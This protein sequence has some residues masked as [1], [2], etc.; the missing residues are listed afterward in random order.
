MTTIAP[1]QQLPSRKDSEGQRVQ[2]KKPQKLKGKQK[3][4]AKQAAALLAREYHKDQMQ[5]KGKIKTFFKE[6]V[7]PIAL[8]VRQHRI[9]MAMKKNRV[10][11][12]S[13]E[14][15]KFAAKTTALE[16]RFG[17]FR[18]N[19]H[20]GD[21]LEALKVSQEISEAHKTLSE[22]AKGQ[23]HAERIK[24]I[25]SIDGAGF[26]GDVKKTIGE[27]LSDGNMTEE[28]R[29]AKITKLLD[30]ASKDQRFQDND[31]VKG[32]VGTQ[33]QRAQTTDAIKAMV[34]ALRPLVGKHDVGL[35]A[36]DSL[37]LE[38]SGKNLYRMQRTEALWKGSGYV[39]TA[40]LIAIGFATGGVGGAVAKTLES[41]VLGSIIGYP[42]NLHRIRYE[43]FAHSLDLA[44]GANPN[45]IKTES[46]GFISGVAGLVGMSKYIPKVG[47][48]MEPVVRAAQVVRKVD[49]VRLGRD[50]DPKIRLMALQRAITNSA[51]GLAF[52]Y[53]LRW[54]EGTAPGQ[55]VSEKMGD[56]A[57]FA[58]STAPGK[59]V[60][61]GVTTAQRDVQQLWNSVFGEKP[62]NGCFVAGT[63][64]LMADRSSKPIEQVVVGEM[65]FSYDETLKQIVTKKVLA[66]ISP[67]SQVM[68]TITFA[69]GIKTTNTTNHRYLV[70]DKG[71]SSFDPLAT[72]EIDRVAVAKFVVGDK[73]HVY[74]SEGLQELE[75]TNL[76][77]FEKQTQTYNLA[78]IE[79]THTFFANN[80]LVHNKFKVQTGGLKPKQADVFYV[81]RTSDGGPVPV[82]FADGHDVTINIPKGTSIL[83]STDRSTIY[84]V[85]NSTGT[86]VASGHIVGTNLELD[87]LNGDKATDSIPLP[88]ETSGG[89]ATLDAAQYLAQH[90][91]VPVEY[92]GDPKYWQDMHS[93]VQ[94]GPGGNNELILKYTGPGNYISLV[95]PNNHPPTAL[96]FSNSETPQ[97][98]VLD[99][100]Q[101]DVMHA[102]IGAD[103]KPTG[104]SMST[105]QILDLLIDQKQKG[106]TAQ[107]QIDVLGAAESYAKG[108][109]SGTQ[110][111]QDLIYRM[112]QVLGVKQFNN[113]QS[114][115]TVRVG[116]GDLQNGVMKVGAA[117]QGHTGNLSQNIDLNTGSASASGQIDLTTGQHYNTLE[118]H[119]NLGPDAIGGTPITN[120]GGHEFTFPPGSGDKIV[121]SGV[122]GEYILENGSGNPIGIIIP[123]GNGNLILHPIINGVPIEG[124]GV[125]IPNP[126][127]GGSYPIPSSFDGAYSAVS[128]PSNTLE[129][130][131]LGKGL[132]PDLPG[133]D[134]PQGEIA[135]AVLGGLLVDRGS[136]A[137]R[138]WGKEKGG[139]IGFLA[140]LG[141]YAAI[142]I[143]GWV[144]AGGWTG[145]AAALLLS[146]I[147]EGL[148]RIPR[149]Q[150]GIGA[151][152]IVGDVIGRDELPPLIPISSLPFNIGKTV[153]NLPGGEQEVVDGEEQDTSKGDND[154]KK[155]PPGGGVKINFASKQ[156]KTAATAAFNPKGEKKFDQINGIMRK[157][158]GVY[159]EVA[160]QLGLTGDEFKEG[161]GYGL[162]M[163]R[164]IEEGVISSDSELSAISDALKAYFDKIE[165]TPD[166][167]L[168]IGDREITPDVLAKE[169]IDEVIN[170]A[171]RRVIIKSAI[172]KDNF[173]SIATGAFK[174]DLDTAAQLQDLLIDKLKDQDPALIKEV[175]ES[176]DINAIY[177]L[178]ALHS[179]PKRVGY[180]E[181]AEALNLGEITPAEGQTKKFATL[182]AIGKKLRETD[183]I[184][185]DVLETRTTEFTASH[186]NIDPNSEAAAA[187]ARELIKSLEGAKQQGALARI[188]YDTDKMQTVQHV[189]SASSDSTEALEAAAT[190][191]GLKAQELKTIAESAD[192]EST[193]APLLIR[194]KLRQLNFSTKQL[195]TLAAKLNVPVDTKIA[196]P[197]GTRSATTD[198]MILQIA[199]S[200]YNG[201]RRSG[202]SAAPINA[203]ILAKAISD[204]GADKTPETIVAKLNTPLI[205]KEI[206]DV[207]LDETEL[208]KVLKAYDIEATG[209]LTEKQT[210][211]AEKLADL[212]FTRED[213]HTMLQDLQAAASSGEEIKADRFYDATKDLIQKKGFNALL[214]DKHKKI[215]TEVA[216]RLFGF[217]PNSTTDK[218]I[219]DDDFVKLSLERGLNP[220]SAKEKLD[221]LYAPINANPGSKEIS[222]SL[223]EVALK[224]I[225][226]S[227]LTQK[228]RDD[229]ASR[230][231]GNQLSGEDA[232]TALEKIFNGIEPQRVNDAIKRSRTDGSAMETNLKPLYV[233]SILDDYLAPN[234]TIGDVAKALGYTDFKPS[235]NSDPD[236][237]R[238]E[239]LQTL[240]KYLLDRNVD[241]KRLA[242]QTQNQM[243]GAEYGLA[244]RIAVAEDIIENS[245]AYQ[246]AKGDQAKQ[247]ALRNAFGA[248]TPD[249]KALALAV[250]NRAH[251]A[252]ALSVEQLY[253]ALYGTKNGGNVAET[254]DEVKANIAAHGDGLELPAVNSVATSFASQVNKRIGQIPA[255]PAITVAPVT[256]TVVA[257]DHIGLT[258]E[259][260]SNFGTDAAAVETYLNEKTDA[261]AQPLLARFQ[262][263][264]DQDLQLNEINEHIKNGDAQQGPET[265][266]MKLVNRGIEITMDSSLK[267]A[268]V[269]SSPPPVVPAAP[270]V[271]IPVSV[272]AYESLGDETGMTAELTRKLGTITFKTGPIKRTIDAGKII[273]AVKSIRQADPTAGIDTVWS[274]LQGRKG[275]LP[276]DDGAKSQIKTQLQQYLEALPE[277][278]QPQ[279]QPEIPGG[280][281]TARYDELADDILGDIAHDTNLTPQNVKDVAQILLDESN[282][283]RVDAIKNN[284]PRAGDAG[285]E[286]L[287]QVKAKLGSDLG[288]KDPQQ[289]ADGRQALLNVLLGGLN[290]SDTATSEAKEFMGLAKQAHE[291][292]ADSVD[293]AQTARP[294]SILARPSRVAAAG[295]TSNSGRPPRPVI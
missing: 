98:M 153:E 51:V 212:G 185:F 119:L 43:N 156:Q 66:V 160:K 126:G 101:P 28:Q 273:S 207:K 84:I 159:D 186:Q 75:I 265:W 74:S 198:E 149:V 191:A 21:R 76:A 264:A 199:D 19:F 168:K 38:H 52:G 258:P 59:V 147:E 274:Q 253:K 68:V 210:K 5:G 226:K 206:A 208:D 114:I 183:N 295:G 16:R 11:A 71:W 173:E 167:K 100:N 6:M 193:A 180:S 215:R 53:L 284:D 165:V 136:R 80:V 277:A 102:L 182:A 85:D 129:T 57:S 228:E 36:L 33:E 270:P 146:T 116:G 26:A 247:D 246:A 7:E 224:G 46:T 216:V 107:S 261:N 267:Q 89:G 93:Y 18:G 41:M 141:G 47:R 268:I 144:I 276:K 22:L 79:D 4:D 105:K 31:V 81:Q 120:I 118:Q 62:V 234:A 256:R 279:S 240:T 14:F 20:K 104:D 112:D 121:S 179:L 271:P 292:D 128:T 87:Y 131:G 139:K 73:V 289:V 117:F 54:V 162:M 164:L 95:D 189:L 67:V 82:H 108:H 175:L 111:S 194:G 3:K 254:A 211:F 148:L 12:G 214:G 83:E 91:K 231:A 78:E 190:A 25:V 266:A 204:A 236:I 17:V 40:A 225:I 269:S 135:Y 24:K 259:S 10:T 263:M 252:D 99:P 187:A 255:Q 213:V 37:I 262:A 250:I 239:D 96:I 125:N 184:P 203:E 219:S 248:S 158:G 44:T 152:P 166:K 205:N 161:Q 56:A 23:T 229:L 209:S 15:A 218:F 145:P 13:L 221:A 223:K 285:N 163:N 290:Q 32:L 278:P 130:I 124:K 92:S 39:K 177:A 283:A 192:P 222:S 113:G 48:F 202:Q 72:K 196:T 42:A 251:A 157:K 61:E 8:A 142:P 188:K 140:Q 90:A 150:R 291:S 217:D 9:Y 230:L 69:N 249:A 86:E 195:I 63:T 1:E 77:S 286:L 197:T 143:G 169:L 2:E 123:D 27:I 170:P 65:V 115:F 30:D 260:A 174:K 232:D 97:G 45:K 55:F 171:R 151:I 281:D 287:E 35:R 181:I 60:E 272:N 137:L 245:R 288:G 293:P 233:E 176:G 109:W 34:D 243:Q 238:S 110:D 70:K 178:V 244:I 88:Q 235:D 200:L 94:Q 282:Q 58:E 257:V 49:V 106:T 241:P 275:V 50:K 29:Q 227:Q 103:G 122:P 134:T 172:T 294:A 155:P 242:V 133:R 138:E 280:I 132:F 220:F 201:T 154:K 237:K 64:I 127:D